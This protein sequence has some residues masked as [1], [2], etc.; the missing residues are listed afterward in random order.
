MPLR[1]LCRLTLLLPMAAAAGDDVGTIEVDPSFNLALT[2]PSFVQDLAVLSD[3]RIVVTGSHERVDGR[4]RDGIVVLDPSGQANP[5]FA[6]RCLRYGGTAPAACNGVVMELPDGGFL[7]GGFFQRIDDH[8]VGTIARFANDATLDPTFNP[9]GTR[10][11]A[12][13]LSVAALAPADGGVFALLMNGDG[14]SATVSALV[15]IDLLSGTVDPGF[16][17]PAGI[18]NALAT[19]GQGRPYVAHGSDIVRLDAAT[20]AVDPTWVSGLPHAST[21]NLMHDPAT[22]KLFAVVW[23]QPGVDVNRLVRFDPDAA[24]GYDPTW[25]PLL[26]PDLVVPKWR[27]IEAAYDGLIYARTERAP[28]TALVLRADDGSVRARSDVPVHSETFAVAR[29]P[30]GWYVGNVGWFDPAP[31]VPNGTA[32]HRV[33]DALEWVNDFSSA[34][35]RNGTATDVARNGAGQIAIVG[36]FTRVGGAWRDSVA[37]LHPDLKLDPSWPTPPL[38]QIPRTFP[39]YRI[40]INDAGDVIAR[41]GGS[42]A[43]F[44]GSPWPT[45]AAISGSLPAARRL[46]MAQTEFTAGTDGLYYVHGQFAPTTS[47]TRCNFAELL[48]SPNFACSGDPN[49]VP[50]IVGRV[51]I[52]PAFDADGRIYIAANPPAAATAARVTRHSMAAGAQLDPGWSVQL[53]RQSNASASVSTLHVGA[54]HVYIGGEFLQANQVAAA[55]LVRVRISDAAIDSSW[56]PALA[57]PQAMVEPLIDLVESGDSVYAIQYAGPLVAG[58]RP[59]K[60]IRLP[61]HGDVS[62]VAVLPINGLFDVYATGA[63]QGRRAG[64]VAL[65]GQR[66]MVAGTFTE[67]GGVRRD[68]L[69]VI[70]LGFAHYADGFEPR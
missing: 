48:T 36:D 39:S 38:N 61:R 52:R 66:A 7:L 9:I 42:W 23:D 21:S 15:R 4:R 34:L 31:F 32:V 40:A 59:Y 51:A 20:G 68:G 69:A 64:L 60:V 6:P 70:G 53:E 1:Q 37:R 17:S 2:N 29:A 54:E 41:E 47:V 49:W 12:S 5:T 25:Q 56:L 26:P 3:G 35:F 46:H 19:D 55:G 63:L 30:N 14:V 13:A 67:I 50:S 28:R 8:G 18:R 16:V 10:F 65:P 33:G 57:P 24:V 44:T 27:R 45:A 43:G 62:Q 22:G 11:P 58:R